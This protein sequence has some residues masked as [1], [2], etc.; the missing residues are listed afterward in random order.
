MESESNVYH[1]YGNE[2]RARNTSSVILPGHMPDQER[3]IARKLVAARRSHLSVASSIQTSQVSQTQRDTKDVYSRR[4]CFG[5]YEASA[6]SKVYVKVDVDFEAILKLQRKIEEYRTRRVCNL[7]PLMLFDDFQ[8]ECLILKRIIDQRLWTEQ[9]PLPCTVTLKDL[10]DRRSAH[11]GEVLDYLE[12]ARMFIV[13]V[14]GVRCLVNRLCIQLDDFETRENIEERRVQAMTLGKQVFIRLNMERV[15]FDEGLKMRPEL[16]QPAALTNNIERLL[17]LK[18]AK[19]LYPHRSVDP[20]VI[21]ALAAQVEALY[22]YSM[23]KSVIMSEA[24]TENPKYAC[25]ILG[26]KVERNAFHAT[27]YNGLA[28]YQGNGG[29]I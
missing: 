15:L 16:R 17:G 25:M 13:A 3:A 26:F 28:A 20:S 2:P 21:R 8:T 10:S 5:L 1:R 12:E 7:L 22:C 19:R 4:V 18:R 23:M 29:P 11:P 9:P 27:P 6:L 24:E 14:N